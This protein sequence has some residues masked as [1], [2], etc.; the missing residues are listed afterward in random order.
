MASQSPTTRKAEAN[1]GWIDPGP[2]PTSPGDAVIPTI[3]GAPSAASA[4]SHTVSNP[5]LVPPTYV[6]HSTSE[7]SAASR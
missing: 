3:T 6:A 1:S 7:P 5:L 2:T 4:T